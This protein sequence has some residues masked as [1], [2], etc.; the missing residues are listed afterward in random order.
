[1][2][3]AHWIICLAWSAKTHDV[4]FALEILSPLRLG[5]EFVI[6]F[7]SLHFCSSNKAISV[8]SK[9]HA[10]K[11]YIGGARRCC[12]KRS[13]W[14]I[15][16]NQYRHPSVRAALQIA[17]N[18]GIESADEWAQFAHRKR[19]TK[20]DQNTCLAALFTPGLC[21]SFVYPH[22]VGP[23]RGGGRFYLQAFVKCFT[24]RT[25]TTMQKGW[26]YCRSLIEFFCTLR[27]WNKV[28]IWRRKKL[29]N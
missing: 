4:E 11:A 16:L 26:T 22:W 25:Y 29:S 27:Y 23:Q 9:V 24:S 10:G 18:P 14:C 20:R 5:A 6:G 8:S 7:C 17:R 1:M 21:C 19:V 15:S 2:R 3:Q 13:R 28:E 12:Q